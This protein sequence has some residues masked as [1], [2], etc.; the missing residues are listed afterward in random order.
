M[1]ST[2][3]TILGL[4]LCEGKEAK[5]GVKTTGKICAVPKQ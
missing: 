3:F 5:K 2:N 1:I 4:P